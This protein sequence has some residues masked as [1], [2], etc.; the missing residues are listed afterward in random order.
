VQYSDGVLTAT[1]GQSP[2]PWNGA[3]GRFTGRRPAH[4]LTVNGFSKRSSIAAGVMHR[5]QQPGRRADSF[6]IHR[7]CRSTSSSTARVSTRWPADLGTE[8][9]ID[10]ANIGSANGITNFVGIENLIG[11]SDTTVTAASTSSPSPILADQWHGRW[12]RRQ[13]C[14]SAPTRSTSGD[15]RRR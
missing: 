13:T 14:S 1:C 12:R 9:T 4:Q 6:A 3:G 11:G 2:T 8:W 5:A 7:H 10:G 15:H